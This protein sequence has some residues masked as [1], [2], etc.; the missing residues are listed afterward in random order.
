MKYAPLQQDLRTQ[1]ASGPLTNNPPA[2]WLSI[3][4][5]D[6]NLA[7]IYRRVE[8]WRRFVMGVCVW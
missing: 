7:R 6:M 3:L 4:F 5:K 1:K 8:A 2:V